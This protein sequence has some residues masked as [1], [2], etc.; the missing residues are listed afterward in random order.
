MEPPTMDFAMPSRERH[1]TDDRQAAQEQKRREST[2][3]T[4]YGRPRERKT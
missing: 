4:S 2:D 1:L 3:A